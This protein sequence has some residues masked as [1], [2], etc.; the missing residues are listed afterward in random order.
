MIGAVIMAHG[1]DK[2]LVLPPRLAPHQVVV[3]PIGKD[4]D[5]ASAAEKLAAEIS[6]LG[7]RVHVDTRDASPGF[8]FNDWELRGVPL[9]IELG[10]RD[11]AAGTAVIAMR[12][13]DEGKQTVALDG[14]ASSLPARLDAYHDAL[15][16]PRPGVPRRT[17][18]DGA[19]VGAL[20]PPPA[21][22]VGR[23]TPLRAAGV[24][25]RHQSRDRGHA[26]LHPL[27]RRAR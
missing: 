24:R 2:G 23:R 9:R 25:G 19:D 1:D 18:R 15:A 16:G 12:I 21:G 14:L 22:R 26:P 17:A 7:V 8:K 20:R 6:G 5:V 10:P 27:R 3:V 13:G 11:L 4:P